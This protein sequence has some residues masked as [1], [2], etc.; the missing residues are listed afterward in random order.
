MSQ[1]V[2]K[3]SPT[4]NGFDLDQ[5]QAAVEMVTE[6]PSAAIAGFRVR[7][8]WKGRCVVEGKVE[9][10]TFGGQRIPRR[11]SVVTD[12]PHEL[13]GTDVGPNPQE[14]LFAALNACMAFGFA[15]GAAQRGIDIESLTIESEGS[16]DVRRVMGLV[17][18]DKPGC[19]SIR[20]TVRIKSSAS[21]EQIE[22]LH[23][24][25]MATSPN[26][27]HLASPIPLEPTIVVE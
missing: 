20:Y 5:M 27:Y 19:E 4:V 26:R 22:E 15:T 6:N 2:L 7:S 9:A 10:Y 1:P 8:E 25:V 17:P 24:A 21:R 11:H 18:S 23:E 16:L 3:K 12:E 14:L 13:F